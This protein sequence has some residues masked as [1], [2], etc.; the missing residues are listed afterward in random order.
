MDKINKNYYLDT[1]FHEYKKNILTTEVDYYVDTIELISIGIVSEYSETY[2]A[3]CNEFDIQEAWDNEWLRTNVL[4]PIFDETCIGDKDFDFNTTKELILTYGK[5]K[6]D[7][8]KEIIEFVGELPIFYAYYA[9]YDWVVFCWLFGTMINLPA[10][11]PMYCRDLN[12]TMDELAV[13]ISGG[14]S[15][16]KK[17][18]R[19]PT[20]ENEHNALEDAKWNKHL[21]TFLTALAL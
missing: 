15:A 7:I 4:K 5:S 1:E 13:Q 9:D 16:L 21:H 20:K 11:F 3:I 18:Y 19:F 6:A 8:A 17:D 12:Q 14:R 2:Y 10:G